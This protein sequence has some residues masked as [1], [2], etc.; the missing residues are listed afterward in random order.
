[1]ADNQSNAIKI[2]A[3]VDRYLGKGKK[4]SDAGPQQAELISLVV[5]AIKTELM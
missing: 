2:T 3:I 1:M 4:V 5:D